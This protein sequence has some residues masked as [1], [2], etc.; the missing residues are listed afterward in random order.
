MP[1]PSLT[2]I[3]FC[4]PRAAPA[5]SSPS[6]RT[7]DVVVDPYRRGVALGEPLPDRVVG[8]PRHDRRSDDA[9]RAEL[10]GP[11]HAEAHT[12]QGSV[13]Q[14]LEHAVEPRADD[15]EDRLRSVDH[16]RAGAIAGEQVAREIGD[17]H[18]DARRAEIGGEQRTDPGVEAQGAGRPPAGGRA[19]LPVGDEPE[20]EQL[21]ESLVDERAPE[22]GA[23]GDVRTAALAA[24]AD[25]VQHAEQRHDAAVVARAAAPARVLRGCG[26]GRVRRCSRP[27]TSADVRPIP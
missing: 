24:C 11:R 20:V 3:A 25:V 22:T 13:V 9:A 8:P 23:G 17:R 12:P 5:R 19:E 14:R 2:I 27:S 21:A 6:I 16:V 1:V 4:C 26:F 10:H 15:R 7:V 18:V